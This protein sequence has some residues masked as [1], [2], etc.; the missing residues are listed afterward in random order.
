MTDPANTR[1]L[2]CD[3]GTGGLSLGLY[4]PHA[5]KMEGIGTARYGNLD[6]LADSSWKEQDPRAWIKAIPA[7]LRKLRQ[8]VPFAK[9]SIVGIGIGGHMHALVVLDR[10]NKPVQV[11]GRLLSGAIM[12]DDP[13]GEAEGAELSET[14]E[15]TDR[16]PHDRVA[17]PL[18][19]GPASRGLGS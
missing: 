15:R 17:H 16:R 19:R 10:K 7:A 13:R 12:W 6:G 1:I 4:N 2:A 8:Q 18:V 3:F 11:D 14:A 9:E 5:N